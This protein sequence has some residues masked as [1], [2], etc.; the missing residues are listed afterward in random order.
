MC[1]AIIGHQRVTQ[2]QGRAAFGE[3][4]DK[5]PTSRIDRG[6]VVGN[7]AI[8]N[9]HHP[10]GVEDCTA[11]PGGR[12][13]TADRTIF[14]SDVAQCAHTTGHIAT[15]VAI[16]RAVLNR[17]GA[18]KKGIKATTIGQCCHI[19]TDRT[20]DQAQRAAITIIDTATALPKFTCRCVH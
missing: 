13:I 11:V 12:S 6:L 17:Y 8:E 7:C 9:R 19:V 18:V 4:A 10:I 16:D 15:S 20:V 2:P 3:G 1:A 5:K 14:D